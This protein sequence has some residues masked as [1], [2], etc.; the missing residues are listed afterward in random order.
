[1]PEFGWL[2]LLG[3]VVG[4]FGTLIGAGGGF[5]LMPVLVLVY[6]D[7]P[8]DLLASISL[9]VVFFNAASGSV[10]YARMVRID[11]RSGLLLAAGTLPGAVLGAMTTGR[12]PRDLFD[13]IL[14]TLLIVVGFYLLLRRGNPTGDGIIREG[15]GFVRRFTSGDGRQYAYSYNPY[16][17][18]GISLVV[19]FLSSLLGIGGGII[20]VPALVNL[21][22]F[23]VHVATA[24]SHFIL[25]ITALTGTGVHV[26]QGSLHGGVERT[27]ALSI[28]VVAGAQIGARLAKRV[29]AGLILRALALALISVGVRIV[30]KAL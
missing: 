18:V 16:V 24:T 5:L 11:Y 25:A 9:A 14:G 12:I 27:V 22:H 23:P 2:I 7:D 4:G 30:I 13:G 21:L 20:H 1:V 28:G 8:P 26:F 17:G 29:K 19:G 10:A 15:D 6:P 3:F